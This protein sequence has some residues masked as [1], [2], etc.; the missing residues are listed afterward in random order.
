MLTPT[1]NHPLQPQER[2]KNA[3]TIAL[4]NYAQELYTAYAENAMRGEKLW[5][6]LITKLCRIRSWFRQMKH[7]WVELL[8]QRDVQVQTG[9]DYARAK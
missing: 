1:P 2:K 5:I 4:L 7:K 9:R 6:E 8:N 3:S